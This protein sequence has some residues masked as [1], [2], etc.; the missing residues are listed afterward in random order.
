MYVKNITGHF[1]NERLMI[2]TANA[3]QSALQPWVSLGLLYNQSSPGVRFLNKIIF[4][5]MGLLAHAQPPSWRTRV[6]LLV[7]TPPFDLS[8]LGVSAGS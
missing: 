8:G 5:R 6:S 7:W 4:Y 2:N 3:C 1:G